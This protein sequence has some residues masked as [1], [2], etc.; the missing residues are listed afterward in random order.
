LEI[1]HTE[2]SRIKR[3]MERNL[4]KSVYAARS[5]KRKERIDP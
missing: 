5:R 4:E 3:K 2:F 1:C